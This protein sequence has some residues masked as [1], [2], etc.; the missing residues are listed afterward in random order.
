MNISTIVQ[1]LWNY[2]NGPGLGQRLAGY[3]CP[4]LMKN[5]GDELFDHHRH[6]LEELDEQPGWKS[7]RRVTLR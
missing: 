1:K 5:D 6:T 4:R 3:D 7:M 2:C